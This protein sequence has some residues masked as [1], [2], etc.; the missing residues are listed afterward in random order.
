ML[1]ILSD[2]QFLQEKYYWMSKRKFSLPATVVSATIFYSSLLKETK[3]SESSQKC[4]GLMNEECYYIDIRF[5]FPFEWWLPFPI[6]YFLLIHPVQ[7][8]NPSYHQHICIE[9]LSKWSQRIFLIYNFYP[10]RVVPTKDELTLP[11]PPGKWPLMQ[12]AGTALVCCY[13]PPPLL[14]PFHLS[15][16]PPS[17][18]MVSY[19][20][21]SALPPPLP[22]TMLIHNPL[23]FNKTLHLQIP[24][25]K[26]CCKFQTLHQTY[27]NF[28]LTARYLNT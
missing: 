9:M 4:E 14:A 10:K 15:A 13:R 20:T 23:T 28:F 8:I 27:S 19:K 5:A 11:L 12:I 6:L 21:P 26:V 16:K 25:Y 22:L 7:S 17:K 18:N 1:E 24:F 2:F 3:K